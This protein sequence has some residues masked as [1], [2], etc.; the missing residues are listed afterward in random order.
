M[1][2]HPHEILSITRDENGALEVWQDGKTTGSLC[3]G[4]M[5]EQVVALLSSSSRFARQYPMDTPDGWKRTNFRT[6]NQRKD[7]DR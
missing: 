7:S 6:F 2:D 1:S 5:L 4:E 3:F